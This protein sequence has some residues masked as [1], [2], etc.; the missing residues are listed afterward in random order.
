MDR[1]ARHRNIFD[2]RPCTLVSAGSLFDQ[3]RRI[4]R[5]HHN[6]SETRFVRLYDLGHVTIDEEN[7]PIEHVDRVHGRGENDFRR[8][9]IFSIIVHLFIYFERSNLNI[10]CKTK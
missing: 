10:S 9:E 7:N 6:A 2:E 3:R 5:Q 1:A 4:G 8:G